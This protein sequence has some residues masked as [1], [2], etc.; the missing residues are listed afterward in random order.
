M[1]SRTDIINMW[2]RGQIYFCMQVGKI[3][4]SSFARPLLLGV[5]IMR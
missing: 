1:T 5:E 4:L 3:N 2:E